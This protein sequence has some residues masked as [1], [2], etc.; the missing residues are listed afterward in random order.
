MAG[1]TCD[2]CAYYK[3]HYTFNQRKILRVHCG[4]CM[5]AKVKTRKPDSKACDDY[6]QADS[7]ERAFVSK[8]YLSK[9]LLKYM[10]ELELLPKIHDEE[11]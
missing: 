10:M 11:S 1:E 9:A 3:Q 7:D 8:E 6:I 2:T 4:H 5:F